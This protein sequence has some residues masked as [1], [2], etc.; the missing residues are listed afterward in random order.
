MTSYKGFYYHFLDMETGERFE[1]VELSTIDTTFLLAGAL[2][3][4]EYFDR[5]DGEEREIRDL[6]EKLYARVEWDWAQPNAP[7]VVMG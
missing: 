6:A 1:Q 2:F 7:R 4:G 3:C 5:D